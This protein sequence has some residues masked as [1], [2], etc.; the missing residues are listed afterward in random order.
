MNWH[1]FV[2]ELNGKNVE[3]R[4]IRTFL[5]SVILSLF[6]ATLFFF[7]LVPDQ[8]RFLQRHAF[9]VALAVVSYSFIMTL[10]YQVRAY[11]QF[12]CMS[13]MMIG[14]T[15]GMLAGF[16][17]GFFI[18][19]TNGMFWGSVFGMAVGICIGS[20]YGGNSCGVMGFLEGIMAGFMGGLMGAMTAVMMLSDHVEIAGV[21]VFCIS[22]VIL[23]GLSYMIY[24]ETRSHETKHLPAMWKTALA[25]GILTLVTEAFIV[26]GPRS[27]L[28]G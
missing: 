10:V 3:G 24:T 13:G 15:L 12:P 17:A 2:Q 7:T 18:G 4:L 25:S 11:R 28:F 16:L 20:W 9:F 5:F 8:L 21:I 26:F 22:A 14:M 27:L 23:G 19:A 1:I 6:V